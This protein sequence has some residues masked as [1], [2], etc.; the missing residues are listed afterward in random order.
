M[1]T[2]TIPQTVTIQLARKHGPKEIPL[3]KMPES[4]VLQYL[5]YGV[6][7]KYADSVSDPAKYPDKASVEADA[8]EMIAQHIAGDWGRSRASGPETPERRARKIVLAKLQAREEFKPGK[9]AKDEKARAAL[10]DALT[11]ALKDP[12]WVTL[13]KAQLEQEAALGDVELLQ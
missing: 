7:K 6:Q 11:E 13:A 8:D 4:I 10:A 1:T 2:I 3:G 12:K 5:A 9:L